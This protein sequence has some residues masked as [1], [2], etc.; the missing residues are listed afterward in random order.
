MRLLNS[1]ATGNYEAVKVCLDP[2]GNQMRQLF[3]G[4]G[5]ARFIYNYMLNYLNEAYK[6][7]EKI[8]LSKYGIRNT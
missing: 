2:A 5:A 4:V 7:K 1:T 3:S 6:K 8:D